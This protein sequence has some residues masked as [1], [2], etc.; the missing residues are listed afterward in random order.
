M[1]VK[2]P[3]DLAK[4]CQA[5]ELLVSDVD[6]VLTSGHIVLNDC[7]TEIK[8]FHVRDG[9]A[10]NLWFKAGKQ[11]ALLSSRTSAAVDRRAAD[12][13]ITHVI[14]GSEQ[15][16]APLLRLINHLGLSARQVCYIGD[17]LPDLPALMAVGLAACPADAVSEV[18][19]ASHLITRANGGSGTIREIVELILKSQGTWEKLILMH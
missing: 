8:V 6:G 15:K 16:E 1:G 19:T 17:D 12:L 3:V 13:K 10:F 2:S 11:A 5:I 18:K 7:G 4:R 14:Q 9:L